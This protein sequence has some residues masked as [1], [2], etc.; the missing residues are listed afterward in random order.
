MCGATFL[1]PIFH[2]EYDFGTYKT[3]KRILD[4]YVDLWSQTNLIFSEILC[5]IDET[6][7]LSLIKS[8]FFTYNVWRNFSRPNFRRRP[9]LAL[10]TR[11]NARSACIWTKN[12]H[13][14]CIPM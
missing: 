4:M 3:F 8:K 12:A 11:L 1:D 7:N 14:H 10:I 13:F 6:T 5:K 2:V 9:I